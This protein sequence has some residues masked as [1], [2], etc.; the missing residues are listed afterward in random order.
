MPLK[1]RTPSKNPAVHRVLTMQP[2]NHDPQKRKD[3]VELQKAC[4]ERIKNLK[5]PIHRLK[6]DGECGRATISTTRRVARHLGV[7]VRG[8]GCSEYLQRVVRD[9]SRRTDAQ[10]KR[11]QKYRADHIT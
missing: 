7:G 3:V 4:N 8:Y 1:H 6:V 10:V 9:P 2:H 5:L 11:G